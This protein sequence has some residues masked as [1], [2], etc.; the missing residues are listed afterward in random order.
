MLYISGAMLTIFDILPKSVVDIEKGE[1]KNA[2][3]TGDYAGNKLYY[4]L[5]CIIDVQNLLM[6]S[7][8]LVDIL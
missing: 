3:K 7:T 5:I 2:T 4:T 1:N 6:L 8:R